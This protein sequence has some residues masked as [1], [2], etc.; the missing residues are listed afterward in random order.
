MLLVIFCDWLIYLLRYVPLVSQVDGMHSLLAEL[1]ALVRELAEEA[2]RAAVKALREELEAPSPPLKP[3]PTPTTC[4]TGG[5]EVV[6]DG[7]DAN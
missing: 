5:T 1:M 7:S 2:A 6:K 4:D 3:F